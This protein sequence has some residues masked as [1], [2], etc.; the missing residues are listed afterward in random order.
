MFTLLCI[1]AVIYVFLKI[2]NTRA[3]FEASDAQRAAEQAAAEEDYEEELEEIEEQEE[4]R[5]NAVDVES[6]TIDTSEPEDV[7]FTVEEAEPE[8]EDV[9][10]T[11][12]EAEP[13]KEAEKEKVLETV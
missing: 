5:R 2:S 11:V 6:E 4:I 9:A 12:E 3:R 8:P 1:L 10:F 7:A 13:V